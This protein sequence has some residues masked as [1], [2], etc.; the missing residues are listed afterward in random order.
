V[1]TCFLNLTSSSRSFARFFSA[2]YIGKPILRHIN[3]IRIV[4]A[5]V[6][7]YLKL[8][9]NI[10]NVES[11]FHAREVVFLLNISGISMPNS[12]SVQVFSECPIRICFE[13]NMRKSVSLPCPYKKLKNKTYTKNLQRFSEDSTSLG[14]LELLCEAVGLG[15]PVGH[16]LV[17]LLEALLQLAVHNPS[18][19]GVRDVNNTLHTDKK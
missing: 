13:K 8:I 10:S 5:R 1:F 16:G 3:S 18:L 14:V 19:R 9:A 12:K 15:L 11:A 6:E 17:E 4:Y 7:L 2:V